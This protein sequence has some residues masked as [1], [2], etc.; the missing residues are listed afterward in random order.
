MKRADVST[1]RLLPTA[2]IWGVVPAPL[3]IW[4]LLTYLV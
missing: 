1:R 2:L 4:A 3:Y